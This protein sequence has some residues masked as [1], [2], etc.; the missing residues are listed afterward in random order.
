MA[1]AE[2]SVN[3]GKTEKQISLP[4]KQIFVPGGTNVRQHLPKTKELAALLAEQGQLTP[5]VVANG[6]DEK[7]PYILV[8]GERRMAAFE[9]NGW[10]NREILAVVRK[11][12][13]GDVLSRMADNWAEN[14]SRVAVSPLDQ[15]ERIHQLVTGTYPVAEGEE[16]VPIP[17]KEICARFD[18]SMNHLNQL[19]RVFEDIDAGV[20]TEARK[21]E[22][23]LR[24]LIAMARAKGKSVEITDKIIEK[25][26]ELLE[27]WV[28][29]Q[30]AL[31]AEGRKRKTRSD[32]KGK[33]STDEP[34][35]YLKPTKRFDKRGTAA[36]Y[37]AVLR[38]KEGTKETSKEERMW[39]AGAVEVLRFLIGGPDGRKT[40]PFLV[41]ADFEV[42]VEEEE[43]EVEE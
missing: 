30:A 27:E 25:Q 4:W 13:K 29:Q 7:R 6:G 15:A 18:I 31:E 22:A 33:K 12:A 26:R 41:N 37:L 24:L 14:M 20:H 21:A 34:P 43:E 16:A 28:A 17:K 5:I 11:Y 36:D 40:F 2:E 39:I 38:A 32:K 35:I 9:A 23:P 42:L 19:V 10:Q 1:N 3:R 8:A